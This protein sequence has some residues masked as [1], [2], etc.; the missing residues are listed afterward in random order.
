MRGQRFVRDGKRPCHRDERRQVARTDASQVGHRGEKGKHRALCAL[1][2][3]GKVHVDCREKL[4]ADD[5]RGGSHVTCSEHQVA[6]AHLPVVP[7]DQEQLSHRQDEGKGGRVDVH[8]PPAGVGHVPAVQRDSKPRHHAATH[9]NYPQVGLLETEVH[10]EVVRPSRVGELARVVHHDEQ[11]GLVRRLLRKRV[12]HRMQLVDQPLAVA[13]LARLRGDVERRRRHHPALDQQPAFQSRRC[14]LEEDGEE[15]RRSTCQPAHEHHLADRHAERK[16]LGIGSK[17]AKKRPDYGTAVAQQVARGLQR[18]FHL[19]TVRAL[20]HQGIRRHIGHQV[21]CR[22]EKDHKHNVLERHPLYERRQHKAQGGVQPPPDGK[23]RPPALAADGHAVR[24][25]AVPDLEAPRQGE[26][27]AEHAQL[28]TVDVTDTDK[29]EGQRRQHQRLRDADSEVADRQCDAAEV[30]E[31]QERKGS[32]LVLPVGRA[33]ALKEIVCVGVANVDVAVT[34]RL[35]QQGACLGG[36]I[37]RTWHTRPLDHASHVCP[38]PSAMKYR[39]CSF[40]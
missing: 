33:A 21:A 25:H 29:V 11:H 7:L 39:Y 19:Q 14:L 16:S 6:D 36:A 37:G 1:G 17:R 4:N 40:Y 26:Q 13:W 32:Q 15:Q 3:H 28:C 27:R 34:D 9:R 22:H 31:L 35:A 20:Y 30:C 12:R 5:E 23:V 18:A 8:I 38:H 2:A 10:H 24:Q